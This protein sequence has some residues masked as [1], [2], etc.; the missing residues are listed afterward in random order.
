MMKHTIFLTVLMA[1]GLVAT[2][3]VP[4]DEA[5][6]A[7]IVRLVKGQYTYQTTKAQRLRGYEDWTLTVH[8]DG[9]RTMMALVNNLDADVQFN[10]VHRVA[11]TFRPLETFVTHWVG[12]ESRGSGHFVVDGRLLRATVTGQV[13]RTI[14]VPDRFSMHPHP[15][16][17]D[18]WRTG[19]YDKDRGGVQTARVY[20][21]AVAPNAVA[22]LMGVLEDQTVE[23][24]GS[25]TITVPAGT[26][27]TDHYKL[28]GNSDMWIA[29]P[30]RIAIKYMFL[31]LDREYVLTTYESVA[32][33]VN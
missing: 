22:P 6:N 9:S 5:V 8:P 14:Q 3:T 32:V 28:R 2:T 27:D 23:W 25:E 29:G 26:F 7:N 11:A 24:L 12:G 20:N 19:D 31:D 21:V 33:G 4:A 15:V 16:S 17:T 1:L 18:S 30:D 10:M 13:S